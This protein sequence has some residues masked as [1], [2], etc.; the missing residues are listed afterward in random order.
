M[1]RNDITPATIAIKAVVR[2]SKL[3]SSSEGGQG[4]GAA[5]SPPARWLVVLLLDGKVAFPVMRVKLMVSRISMVLLNSR[6][7]SL[8]YIIEFQPASDKYI[9]VD[10][11]RTTAM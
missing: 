10:D 9:V 3:W 5:T 1:V 8:Q 11:Y 2:C 6:S 7:S 4:E